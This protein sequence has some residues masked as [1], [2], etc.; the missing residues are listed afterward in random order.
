[1]IKA[2]YEKKLNVERLRRVHEI[3]GSRACQ[4]LRPEGILE[5]DYVLRSVGNS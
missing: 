4:Y 1:M 3:T 5:P 2:C